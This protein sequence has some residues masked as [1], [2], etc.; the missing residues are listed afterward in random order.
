MVY[1]IFQS[2]GLRNEGARTSESSPT[3][4][5]Y[6]KLCKSQSKYMTA[7]SAPLLIIFSNQFLSEQFFNSSTLTCAF[8]SC[9]CF[10]CVCLIQ[11]GLF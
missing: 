9:K 2:Q 5:G 11:S 1:T 4:Y 8:Y 3:Y 6:Q 7:L 10:T